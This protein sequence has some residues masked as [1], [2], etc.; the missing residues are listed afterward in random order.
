M[1][2]KNSEQIN[3][4]VSSRKVIFDYLKKIIK[5]NS[6]NYRTFGVDVEPHISSVLVE[7]FKKNKF[8]KS[9]KDY[10]IAPDK[11]Y[12]PDFEL[13]LSQPLAIEY[14]SGSKVKLSKGKWIKCNNSNNDM[15]TLNTWLQKIKKY[16]D[17]NIYYIFIVYKI[18]SQT[19]N[20]VDVQIAPFYKFLG[21]NKDGL[22]KYREK[23]GNL[24]PKD[25]DEI[26]PI[27]SFGQ[28]KKL[29]QK[30]VIYRSRRIIKKHRTILKSLGFSE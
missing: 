14:K 24:R 18:D 26:P 1:A 21:L 29:F 2:K 30:T 11:N 28:F 16:G 23:D 15:G 3:V 22:L 12:F 9:E 25:F 4:L 20:I 10:I 19:K 7:I 6:F 27:K 17:E 8:I 5:N 13:K